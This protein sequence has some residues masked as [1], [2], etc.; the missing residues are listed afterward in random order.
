MVTHQMKRRGVLTGICCFLLLF[1]WVHLACAARDPRK[2]GY[3]VVKRAL[4]KYKHGTRGYFTMPK[5]CPTFILPEG[6]HSRPISG[7][8][9]VGVYHNNHPDTWLAIIMPPDKNGI[10]KM[11]DGSIALWRDGELVGTARVEEE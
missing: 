5:G 4:A 9:G 10:V 2:C 8:V 7:G 6:F 1:A 11:N 3:T